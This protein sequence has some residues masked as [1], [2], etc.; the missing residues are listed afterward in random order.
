MDQV[1]R[2]AEAAARSRRRPC[3]CARMG[4]ANAARDQ[5]Q[6][7]LHAW[8]QFPFGLVEIFHIPHDR[9][10]DISHVRAQLMRAAGDRFRETQAQMRA[11]F[12]ST[13]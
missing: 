4:Y 1:R 13:A 3:R 2:Y 6:L 12:S 8:R 7:V 9:V 10:A 11:A 5:M